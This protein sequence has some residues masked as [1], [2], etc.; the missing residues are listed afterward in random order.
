M[1]ES[2]DLAGNNKAA[3]QKLAK[4]AKSASEDLVF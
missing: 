2:G 1:G 3:S 4:A